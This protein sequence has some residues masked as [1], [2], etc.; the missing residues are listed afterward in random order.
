M[1][2]YG[3]LEQQTQAV[4]DSVFAGTR[5]ATGDFYALWPEANGFAI[6]SD[7]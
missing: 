7:Y 6:E 1:V 2:D 3:I 5:T 4:G